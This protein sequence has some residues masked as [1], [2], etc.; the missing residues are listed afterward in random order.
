MS[1]AQAA[2]TGSRGGRWLAERRLKIALGIAVAEGLLVAIEK[3]VTRWTV[4]IVAVPVIAFYILAGRTLG[5]GVG[6]QVSWIAA[7]SQAISVI[8]VIL[9]I[10]IGWLAFAAVAVI[11]VIALV[12][13]VADRPS[14]A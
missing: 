1:R 10:V 3:D 7:A 2:S 8:V 5:S 9:G 6:R 11:A 4:I 12:Y 13:L 14:A